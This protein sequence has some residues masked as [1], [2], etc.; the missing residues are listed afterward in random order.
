MT[1]SPFFAMQNNTETGEG[2]GNGLNKSNSIS[3][4]LASA[5][6]DGLYFYEQVEAFCSL[7]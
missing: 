2:Y 4:E 3:N 1:N 5:I 7:S 6:N